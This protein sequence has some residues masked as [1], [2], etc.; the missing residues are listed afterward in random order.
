MKV[1][2]GKFELEAPTVYS[3]LS[4]LKTRNSLNVHL[5]QA[6][7]TRLFASRYTRMNRTPSPDRESQG[8]PAGLKPVGSVNI[9]TRTAPRRRWKQR[10]TE[11]GS[12]GWLV[13]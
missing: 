1:A 11:S 2:E 8:S 7:N 12:L 10:A 4:D 6:I 3:E 9:H 13:S 5:R